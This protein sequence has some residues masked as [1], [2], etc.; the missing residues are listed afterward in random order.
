MCNG[1]T[2]ERVKLYSVTHWWW[3]WRRRR[4]S[5][6]SSVGSESSTFAGS[7][8]SVGPTQSA[9][10]S[11]RT[12]HWVIAKS[13]LKSPGEFSHFDVR[14][15][16]SNGCWAAVTSL[17]LALR[18][19]LHWA[20]HHRRCYRKK[21]ARTHSHTHTYMSTHIQAGSE[22]DRLHVNFTWIISGTFLSDTDSP[23]ISFLRTVSWLDSTCIISFSTRVEH[24]FHIHGY[25]YTST[26]TIPV[27]LWFI[28]F[29]SIDMILYY[30]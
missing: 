4:R 23:L 9:R 17:L 18:F 14:K 24:A 22:A 26:N 15:D 3:R 5:S 2:S 19:N 21:S 30:R 11:I 27:L 29:S 13:Q 8:S 10:I 28:F 20:R 16:S 6:S 12:R 25:L 7:F 1:F